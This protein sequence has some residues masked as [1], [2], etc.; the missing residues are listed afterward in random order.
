M[1]T[2][3]QS[4]AVGSDQMETVQML[5]GMKREVVA[6]GG[7]DDGD[8]QN[9]VEPIANETTGSETAIPVREARQRAARHTF[10]AI[11]APGVTEVFDASAQSPCRHT[12]VVAGPNS[13]YSIELLGGLDDTNLASISGAK[14]VP[15][16]GITVFSVTD[17]P[18]DFLQLNFPLLGG[19][20]TGKYLGVS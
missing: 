3:R 9:I 16:G 8:A 4:V 7:P 5:D 18:V 11:N 12:V 15:G 20:A 6:L 2:N 19:P 10:A 13:H 17:V 14:D 1:T